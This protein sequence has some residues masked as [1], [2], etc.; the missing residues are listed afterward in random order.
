M[1]YMNDEWWDEDDSE[2]LE[3]WLDGWGDGYWADWCEDEPEPRP[4]TLLERIDLWVSR[5]R[6]GQFL[7]DHTRRHI[8]IDDI[9]F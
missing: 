1:S 2:E 7:H 6:I 8:D 3:D 5:T 9:P 4:L